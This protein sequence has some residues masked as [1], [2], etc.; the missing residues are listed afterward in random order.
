MGATGLPTP[1]VGDVLQRKLVEVDRDVAR[2]RALE[3]RSVLPT[4]L[5][6]RHGEV[7]FRAPAQPAHSG[8]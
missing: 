4:E 8:H 2:E 5:V 6:S 7:I 3:K 1:R